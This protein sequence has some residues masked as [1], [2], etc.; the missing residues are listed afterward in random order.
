[1]FQ[2]KYRP[3]SLRAVDGSSG[4]YSGSYLKHFVSPDSLIPDPYNSLDY[5]RY[6]YSRYNPLKYTDSTGHWVETALDIAFITYDVYDISANGLNWENG[7]SLA[8][9]VVGAALPLVTGGGLAVRAFAHAD[10]AIKVANTA[11]NVIDTANATDNVMDLAKEANLT[12]TDLYAFGNSTAPRSPRSGK[13]VFPDAFG[14][15]GPE[16]PPFPN[17]A[18]TFADPA[19]APLTGPYYKLP[20]G[21]SLP[22][23]MSVLPDGI[24]VNPLSTMPETHNTLYPSKEM[25]YDIFVR[26]FQNLPWQYVGKK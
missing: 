20:G 2:N 18:S 17:G 10:D 5:N 22:D 21:T 4:Y 9:D 15:I 23:G 26:L 25:P 16:T 6:S 13:D 1:M 11:D 8:A 19:K 12:P 24:D 7:L 3:D 14:N